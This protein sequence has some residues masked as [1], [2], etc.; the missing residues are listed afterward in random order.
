MH[1][2]QKTQVFTYN[3]INIRLSLLGKVTPSLKIVF[4]RALG[5]QLPFHNPASSRIWG[6]WTVML[7]HDGM[8]CNAKV[9]IVI[10]WLSRWKHATVCFGGFFS[11]MCTPCPL[12][13]YEMSC[14][15]LMWSR[16]RTMTQPRHEFM[17]SAR[18]F[19]IFVPSRLYWNLDRFMLPYFF[20]VL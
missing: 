13:A 9:G 17:A 2:S 4:K 15:S 18:R 20:L 12:V 3:I 7:A 8:S 6:I 5:W 11:Q 14:R 10:R 16:A 1:V 19:K